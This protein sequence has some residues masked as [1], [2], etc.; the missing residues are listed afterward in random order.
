MKDR[1]E[2][3][4]QDLRPVALDRVAARRH[5]ERREADLAAAFGAGAEGFSA[6]PET[7]ARRRVPRFLTA[8]LAAASVAAIAV[9]V[10]AVNGAGDPNG[11]E[12]HRSVTHT[13]PSPVRPIDARTVLLASAETAAKAPVTTGR[14]WYTDE[15][16]ESYTDQLEKRTK[17]GVRLKVT[18]LSYGAFVSG[19][20]EKWIARDGRDRTRSITGIDVRTRFSSPADEAEWRRTGAPDLTDGQKRSVNDYDIPIRYTI[21]SKQVGMDQL[22][23]LPTSEPGLRAE[24]RRRWKADRTGP[25][26]DTD[27]FT[28]FV[29]TTAQDL[30]AGPIT[31]GTKA[32]LYRVLAAQPGIQ[33]VGEVKDGLGRTGQAL[34]MADPP[35]T[36]RD[37]RAGQSRLIIDPLTG[38]LL[39]YEGWEAG[40][41][42]PTLS[43]VYRSMGWVGGLNKRS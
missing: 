35:G 9:A 3:A 17:P 28:L 37:G 42:F 26:A 14:Y 21:G 8:G 24:L 11:H 41:T 32:A 1:H 22:R 12:G 19:D 13:S 16:T 2:S 7:S 20:E 4:F 27:S 33:Y 6:T 30:L 25:D 31:P 10:I 18:K 23:K 34:A 5:A 29:W 39:A 36:W 38:R 15:R 43:D 40:R